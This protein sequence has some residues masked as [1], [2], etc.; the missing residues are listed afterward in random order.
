VLQNIGEEIFEEYE[1]IKHMTEFY[2]KLFGLSTISS[3]NLNGIEC[4]H[5]PEE[6]RQI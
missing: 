5:I 2:K 4:G 3:L 1:L 6:D